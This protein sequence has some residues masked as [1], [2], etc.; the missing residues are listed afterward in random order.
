MYIIYD[1]HQMCVANIILYFL[2]SDCSV[3]KLFINHKIKQVNNPEHP[4]EVP[5]PKASRKQLH[6]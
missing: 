3:L 4:D 6:R 2:Y 1:N 5:K